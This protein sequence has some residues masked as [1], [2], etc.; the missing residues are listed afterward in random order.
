PF[1]LEVADLPERADDLFELHGYSYSGSPNMRD[2]RRS[3]ARRQGSGASGWNMPSSHSRA[4]TAG[5]GTNEF[6]YRPSKKSSPSGSRGR[7]PP[8]SRLSAAYPTRSGIEGSQVSGMPM[9]RL[10]TA[11]L[12]ADNWMPSP[13]S[14]AAS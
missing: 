11:G 3:S 5:S 14:T 8:A 12:M 1:R 4:S 13:S 2:R 10:G 7:C 9:I 6:P